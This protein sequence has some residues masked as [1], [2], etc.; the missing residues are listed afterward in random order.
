MILVSE[1]ALH[2]L[3]LLKDDQAFAKLERALY[4]TRGTHKLDSLQ[5]PS[6]ISPT[7]QMQEKCVGAAYMQ[8]QITKLGNQLDP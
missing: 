7:N 8:A 4:P 6:Y 2:I 5:T 1:L 3:K